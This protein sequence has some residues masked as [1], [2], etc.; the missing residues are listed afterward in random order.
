M[1]LER[2]GMRPTEPGWGRAW[3]VV[4][5]WSGQVTVAV[6]GVW[7]SQRRVEGAESSTEAGQ[8]STSEEDGVQDVGGG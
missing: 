1:S 7:G 8:D 2:G 6:V 3:G 5:G 4:M